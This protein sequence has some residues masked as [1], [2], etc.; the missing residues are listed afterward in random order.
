MKNKKLFIIIGAV[1][2]VS[3]SSCILFFAFKN[4]SYNTKNSLVDVVNCDNV[5]IKENVIICSEKTSKN[6]RPF[7]VEEN[8][9]KF[10]QS[11]TFY[12]QKG[13]M[14]FQNFLGK[15]TIIFIPPNKYPL[16]Y[17]NYTTRGWTVID[18]IKK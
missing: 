13:L 17:R 16:L 10:I 11:S 5:K 18:L 15:K 1:L 8:L 4:S 2:F 14:Y 9:L 12:I 3:I 6:K 7:A